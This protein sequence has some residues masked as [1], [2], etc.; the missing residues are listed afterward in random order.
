MYAFVEF[1]TAERASSVMR[2]GR[3]H[4]I[5]GRHLVVRP[6]EVKAVT[7]QTMANK[8]FANDP[9]VAA[10]P[11]IDYEKVL[12]ALRES[13]S[14]SVNGHHFCLIFLVGSTEEICS[15]VY[16]EIHILEVGRGATGGSCV[17]SEELLLFTEN[18]NM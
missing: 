3:R 18:I 14:V 17:T 5:Q 6:K 4:F 1:A 16:L 12:K 8:R 7:P 10:S 15:K 11:S 2:P 9:P 13:E